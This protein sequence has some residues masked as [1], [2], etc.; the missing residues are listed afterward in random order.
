MEVF[1]RF[2]NVVAEDSTVHSHGAF[3]ELC[4]PEYFHG[5]SN[6]DALQ[7][8]IEHGPTNLTDRD[9]GAI[10]FLLSFHPDYRRVHKKGQNRKN[11]TNSE[12]LIYDVLAKLDNYYVRTYEEDKEVW[13]SSA[14]EIIQQTEKTSKV[15][16]ETAIVNELLRILDTEEIKI[17]DDLIG[18]E[19]KK[20]MYAVYANGNKIFTLYGND[21]LEVYADSDSP[22]II[23]G[24]NLLSPLMR[25]LEIMLDLQIAKEKKKQSETLN[26]LRGI[27]SRHN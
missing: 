15:P 22:L 27:G 5:K 1:A 11:L 13:N 26:W 7:E 12:Q 14:K 24:S 8:F 20:L 21:K 9:I 17:W 4:F 16:Y 19:P 18:L 10:S 2:T 23:K 6:R 3:A 25:K